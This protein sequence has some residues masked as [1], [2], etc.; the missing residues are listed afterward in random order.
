MSVGLVTENFVLDDLPGSQAKYV[1]HL[2]LPTLRD[3]DVSHVL[4]HIVF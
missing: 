4:T 2:I 1:L 3:I